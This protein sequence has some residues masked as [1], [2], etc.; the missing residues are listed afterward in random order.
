M[1]Y[2]YVVVQTIYQNGDAART[3]FGIAAVTDYDGVTTVLDSISDI[4]SDSEPIERLV[5]ICNAEQL[6]PIHLQD[7]VTDFLATV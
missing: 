3:G 6:D 5:E 2:K 4:A 1:E 7:V